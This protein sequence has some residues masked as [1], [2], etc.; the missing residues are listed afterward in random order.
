[1]II[2]LN[3][4]IIRISEV[5]RESFFEKLEDEYD[6]KTADEVYAVFLED[7]QTRTLDEA[8]RDHGL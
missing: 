7:P 2:L 5:L 3:R 8:M 4:N 6:I 1:M